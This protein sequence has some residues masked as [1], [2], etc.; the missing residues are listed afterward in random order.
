MAKESK[1]MQELRADITKKQLIK[2]SQKPI[3]IM[4]ACC[5]KVKALMKTKKKLPNTSNSQLTKE[6]LKQCSTM[7]K[8]F[9]KEKELKKISKKQVII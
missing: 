9:T 3:L 7:E 1:Q 4:A 6:T 5:I 8:C 2:D